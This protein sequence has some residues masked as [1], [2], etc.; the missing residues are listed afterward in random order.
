MNREA[1]KSSVNGNIM[2]L[3]SDLVACVIWEESEEVRE[4]RV[5]RKMCARESRLP[6]HPQYEMK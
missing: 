2:V 1:K 5:S 6:S 4:I 3:Y